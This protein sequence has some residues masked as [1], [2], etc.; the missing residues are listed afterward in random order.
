LLEPRSVAVVGASDRPSSVGYVLLHNLRAG[1]FPGEV[2]AINDKRERVQGLACAR[3]VRELDRPVDLALIA[4]PAAS[5]PQVMRDCGKAGVKFAALLSAGFAERGPEGARLQAD[6]LEIARAGGV[7]VLGPNCLGV[8]RPRAKLHAI[9]GNTRTRPGRLA[10]VSQSGAVCTAILDW[11]E[12]QQIGFSAVLSL[13]AAA[14]VG[15]GE[16]L[17]YLAGDGETDA[18]L[19]YLEGVDHPRRFMSGL[20]VAARMKPVIAF[21]AGRMPA[22]AHAAVTHSAAL[23][24]DDAVFASALRRA[25]AV[26]VASFEELF[27]AAEILAGGRRTRGDRLAIVTNAGGLGVMAADRAADLGLP[28]ATLGA[29]TLAALDAAL[30]PHWSHGNPVDLIGDAPPQRYAAAMS[31]VLA[32]PG[33][34]GVIALLSPQAMTEPVAVAENIAAAS[35]ASEKPVLCCFSGGAQ[36]QKAHAVLAKHQLPNLPTPEAAVEAFGDLVSFER[37]QRLLLQVPGPLADE[38]P[39]DLDAARALVRDALED[40]LTQLPIDRAKAVLRALRIEVTESLPAGHAAEA[41]RAATKLGFPVA[42]K[43]DSDALSHKSDVGGV[44]LGLHSEAAVR[45]AFA[46]ILAEAR[47]RAPNAELRGVTVERMHGKRSGRELFV[48]VSRDPALGPAIAFG[49]GGTLVELIG[50][51]AVALPPLNRTLAQALIERSGVRKWLGT[52]RGMPPADLAALETVI[53]RVS[54]LVCELPEVRELDINPLV[55]DEHGAIAVDARVVLQPTEPTAERYAHMAI[56]PF[57]THLV[58]D[59]KLLDGTRVTL[60]PIRPEDAQ[61]EQSFV[62]ALSSEARHFRFRQGLVELTPPMLVRFT[63]IDYDREMALV[64]LVDEQGSE[65][66]V[67]VARYVS[68]SDGESC[69]F[70]VVVADAFQ[71][72][73]LGSELLKALAEVA[74]QKGL[75]R[76]EGEVACDNEKMLVLMRELGFEVRPHPSDPALRL[77]ELDLQRR[78]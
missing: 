48:G 50:E 13:G 6:V 49:A 34:D 11:A 47:A 60:R 54:E 52:F 5:V 27:F 38:R 8:L 53:M 70:A 72:R 32:D 16:V 18:I 76:M 75:L 22:G 15:F 30:P 28:L 42:L 58:R 1:G 68:N 17:D 44:R 41:E 78:A 73:G 7:R 9:F 74:R 62:R 55:V 4:V 25:G 77:V 40:G 2:F 64:A 39:A 33:V 3:S 19:V 21:K 56:E 31:E 46:E 43:V 24:G 14:D 45:E 23:V 65:R 26:R 29:A 66:E 20:R 71:G 37:N 36:V 57:P 59:I 67:G 12:V 35:S 69:E 61:M 63:Q 10:L 51:H